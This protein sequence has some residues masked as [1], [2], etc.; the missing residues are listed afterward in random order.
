[1]V[2][3]HRKVLYP[4]RRGS[5]LSGVFTVFLAL[6]SAGAASQS[7]PVLQIS[8]PPSGIVISPGQIVPV[9][10]SSP[11]PSAFT[12]ILLTGQGPLGF[13]IATALPAQFS[14]SVPANTAPGKYSLVASGRTTSGAEV[15]STAIIIEVERPDLPTKIADIPG[16]LIFETQ[17][18]TLSIDIFGTFSDGSY[19]PLAGSSY[20]MFSSS[21]PGVV[22][23]DATG[24]ATAISAGSASIAATY[25]LGSHSI[26]FAVP[27][28][29]APPLLT[30]SPV[31]LTF[32]NQAVGSTSSAQALT[33]TN[34]SN[35]PISVLAMGTTGD[36]SET[37]N[38]V[39]LSPLAVSAACTV[40]AK[41]VPSGTGPA[42]G[43]VDITND[44]TTALISIP[45]SGTGTGVTQQSTSVLVVSSASPSVLGQSV[46]LTAAVSPSSGSTIPTGTITF[47]DGSNNIGTAT[48]SG[49]QA[50]LTL[51]SFAVASHSIT[52]AY[53]GDNSFFGS[54]SSAFTQTV[55]KASTT[56]ALT[57]SVNPLLLNQSVTFT[58]TVSVVS[59]GFGTPT[60]TITFQDGT[61]ALSTVPLNSSGSAIFTISSLAVAAHQINATYNG[62]A[63]FTSSASNLTENVSY[64]I[65]VLYDQTKSVQGGA[66][67][68][69]K[70]YLCDTSGADVSSSSVVL[71]ATQVTNL[72]GFS[73][74]VESA[75]NANPDSDFRFDPT[76]GPS[77]GYIFNLKTTGLA[78][79]TY[80]LQFTPGTDPVPHAVIFGVK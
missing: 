41:F 71:H 58:A 61:T 12:N 36:F 78:S 50:T 32:G 22:T 6:T 8:S 14:V 48:L 11:T 49:A 68:P 13:S 65:C 54:T 46:T 72:S 33:L 59:P 44:F 10:V 66:T 79:G 75:G 74:D 9:T 20:L 30:A 51:S 29:V 2:T 3:T 76:L 21:N 34:V 19:L 57:A 67:F 4:F 40:N 77:G 62:D 52:A 24:I 7:P 80:S 17:G 31:S 55:N 45:L 73:G 69:I 39:S 56:N 28:T 23:V 47:L 60:G 5:I 43:T 26:Q 18:E 16:I 42:A 25:A 35:G 53:N 27:V 70:L 37:D 1:M 38:C 15:D 63:N 64:A